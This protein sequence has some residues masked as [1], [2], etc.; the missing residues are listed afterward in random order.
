ME[1]SWLDLEGEVVYTRQCKVV[2][3]M[4]DHFQTNIYSTRSQMMLILLGV[5]HDRPGGYSKS[6]VIGLIEEENY[7]AKQLEDK[8]P[9]KS[10]NCGESRWLTSFA[11]AR[12][13]CVAEGFFVDD[14]VRDSWQITKKGV[15]AF[16]AIKDEF[17]TSYFDCR[18]CYMWSPAFK[19]VMFSQ[20]QPTDMDAARP[21]DV[22]K[23]YRFERS[24]TRYLDMID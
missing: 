16:I 24:V 8:K 10:K 15:N 18:K 3:N 7:F 12:K 5:L 13:D 19:K 22:Y 20:Y 21:D 4:K 1:R 17:A 6:E 23:D 14:D 2:L 9:F 11:F